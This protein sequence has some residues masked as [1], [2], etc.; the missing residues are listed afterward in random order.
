MSDRAAPRVCLP[1]YYKWETHA[2]RPYPSYAQ[3][4]NGN[5]VDRHDLRHED[6]LRRY[7]PAP[8]VMKDVTAAQFHV[9]RQ[10]ARRDGQPGFVKR[11]PAPVASRSQFVRQGEARVS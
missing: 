1:R 5:R 10:P 9:L 7:H 4:E 8:A 2:G 3:L 6:V 11:V